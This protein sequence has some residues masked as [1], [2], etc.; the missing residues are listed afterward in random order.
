MA[1]FFDYKALFLLLSF[2]ELVHCQSVNEV[3]KTYTTKRTGGEVNLCY[4]IK[5]IFHLATNPARCNKCRAYFPLGEMIFHA[6]KF[7]VKT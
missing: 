4:G 6:T 3:F 1:K 7:S 2:L 5:L